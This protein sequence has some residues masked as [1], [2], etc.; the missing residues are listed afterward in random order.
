MNKKNRKPAIRFKAFN[1]PWE[2]RKLSSLCSLFTDGDWIESKDQS[3]FGIRLIQTGNIG[4]TEFIE[5]RKSR[6]WISENTFNRLHCEAVFPGDILISRLPDPAGRACIVPNL[7][8]KMITVVD[9]T[10]ARV[11]AKFC[12]SFLIQSLSTS[13]YFSF[14]NTCLAGGTRQRISRSN[15]SNY[16]VSIPSKKIEQKQIGQYFKLL[17]SLITL[18]QRKLDK[19]QNVKKACLEKMFPQNGESVPRIRFKGFTDTWE[20]REFGDL[21]RR[22]SE[23]A[24]SNTQLPGLEYEDLISETGQLNKD[25]SKKKSNKKGL[26]F[27][28]GDILFGKLRP[29]L[30]NWLLADF[31][32]VAVGDFW[33]L[34]PENVDNSFIYFLIQTP[35]FSLISNISSGSKMPRSDW[36]YVSS[37]TFKLPRSKTEQVKIGNLFQQV[38]S[39]ITLHQRKLDKLKNL[40]KACLEKM[41]V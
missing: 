38:D 17:D 10:I 33:V 20:Q 31:S 25:I 37:A 36:G 24:I 12:A 23:Q 29:Y 19:L 7:K 9:C 35:T 8:E 5:K 40:K 26:L 21:V 16:E 32:G 14:V 4:I 41:F 2:Q 22:A 11:D 18:H 3:N 6:K 1:D 15:L 39:L 27:D 34:R 13:N 30:K 28:K